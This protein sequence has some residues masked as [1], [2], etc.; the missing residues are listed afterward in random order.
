MCSSLSDDQFSRIRQAWEANVQSRIKRLSEALKKRPQNVCKPSD[1]EKTK[2][3]DEEPRDPGSRDKD[4][5]YDINSV[6]QIGQVP[7]SGAAHTIRTVVSSTEV[8]A[9]ESVFCDAV[10]A[11]V[12]SAEEVFIEKMLPRA[13]ND[14]RQSFTQF[15]DYNQTIGPPTQFFLDW[16]KVADSAMKAAHTEMTAVTQ[17]ISLD[18][19]Q[20][21]F[22]DK[23]QP[24][25]VSALQGHLTP[26]YAATASTALGKIV[27]QFFGTDGFA[28]FV[29]NAA[30]RQ[31]MCSTDVGGALASEVRRSAYTKSLQDHNVIR[32]DDLEK[33]AVATFQAQQ[34][35]EIAAQNAQE[36]V[37][38]FLS[39][40]EKLQQQGNENA[41]ASI[42]KLAE[43]LQM[44]KVDDNTY[45][46]YQFKPFPTG[47]W[48]L[49]TGR[50]GKEN[51]GKAKPTGAVKVGGQLTLQE[52]RASQIQV[53][54]GGSRVQIKI[55]RR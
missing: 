48:A 7:D 25:V 29:I 41:Q 1:I 5:H 33:A 17:S 20:T 31:A 9:L 42:D 10:A 11:S 3:D 13:V 45:I 16:P 35:I 28:T 32:Q 47:E 15:D 22:L 19:A 27:L 37:E 36:R 12:V 44:Q 6:D 23:L 49:R 2:K 34:E 51:L 18:Q 39:S 46:L 43:Q 50:F 30:V 14:L 40:V 4:G 21:I 8:L 24:F 38:N 26:I 52:V 54:E 55:P 53:A